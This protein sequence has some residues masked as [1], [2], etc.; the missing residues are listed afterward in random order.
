MAILDFKQLICDL[1]DNS[2]DETKKRL[3]EPFLTYYY[4]ESKEADKAMFLEKVCQYVEK[5][6]AKS[7]WKDSDLS[8]IYVSELIA[9]LKD[10]T[11][12]GTQLAAKRSGM[13]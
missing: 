11:V 5:V 13:R 3:N 10:K 9:I 12:K 1:N 4:T 7:N 6:E 8:G 2:F